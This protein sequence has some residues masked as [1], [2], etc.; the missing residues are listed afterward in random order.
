MKPHIIY[1]RGWWRCGLMCEDV[2]LE[3]TWGESPS[4]ALARWEFSRQTRERCFDART[5]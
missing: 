5:L 2:Q 3:W 1:T 4:L